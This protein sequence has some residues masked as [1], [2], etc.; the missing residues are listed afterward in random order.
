VYINCRFLGVG[1]LVTTVAYLSMSLQCIGRIG[2]VTQQLETDVLVRFTGI[3]RAWRINP[4]VLSPAVLPYIS[5]FTSD[6]FCRAIK[7]LSAS[8]SACLKCHLLKYAIIT[9][10][11]ECFGIWIF[12]IG[13]LVVLTR[14]CNFV[15]FNCIFRFY[16]T[17]H[18]QTN[19]W[20]VLVNY[21]DWQ[22]INCAWRSETID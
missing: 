1:L 16:A 13:W 14:Y 20:C 8:C 19:F 5:H 2:Q 3:D 18:A 11:C 12:E 22:L 21:Y 6:G 10:G 17:I 7:L 15:T 9:N 4:V